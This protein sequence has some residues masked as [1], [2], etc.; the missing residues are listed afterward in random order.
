MQAVQELGGTKT[1]IL[2][3]HRLSTV[4]N[5]DQVIMLE[6]GRVAAADSYEGLVA[7][8]DGFRAL[9]EGAA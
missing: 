1:I 8:H 2:I 3:A 7:R 9:H 6:N 4:R 5:C